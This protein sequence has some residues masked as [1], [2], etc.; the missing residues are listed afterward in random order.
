MSVQYVTTSLSVFFL[1]FFVS[2]QA[3][4]SP[5]TLNMEDVVKALWQQKIHLYRS[6][7]TIMENTVTSS[8]A[9]RV[10]NAALEGETTE[11]TTSSGGGASASS[12]SSS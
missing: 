10:A 12:S 3:N 5:N 11:A 6:Y 8:A 4:D 2:M 1:P 9:E 7:G